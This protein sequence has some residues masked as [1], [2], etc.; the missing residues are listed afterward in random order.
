M[1]AN[2]LD[3]NVGKRNLL[4]TPYALSDMVDNAMIASDG[5]LL[6]GNSY[7]SYMVSPLI[8]VSGAGLY[9]LKVV[10][11]QYLGGIITGTSG[12][13]FYKADGTTSISRQASDMTS[14]GNELYTIQVPEETNYVRFTIYKNSES[15]QARTLACFNQWVFLPNA[16]ADIDASFFVV[17][18]PKTNGAINK[19]YRSDNSYLRLIPGDIIGKNILVFGDSIWGNDRTDGVSDFLAEYSGANIYNCALG[20][21]WI[22]GNRST[23]SGA[24]AWKAFDGV[25]LI[26]AKITNTWTDQDTYVG[27]VTSYA[28]TVLTLLKS[29][30]M[31]KMDIVI[32]SYG[33]NDFNNN[34]SASDIAAAYASAITEILTNY[35]KIRILICSPAWRM[36]N[37][38]DGDEYENTND[39]TLRDVVDAILTMA[40]SNHVEAL[41]MLAHLPWRALT[42]GYYLDNDEVHPNT[43]GNKVY[44]HVVNGKLL[45]MY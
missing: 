16:T 42:K 17:A 26:H 29:V 4:L 7:K 30:D 33:T 9:G 6:T 27:D 31:S 13:A 32:L 15:Y 20:G 28:S 25:N 18:T 40:K 39:E 1:D 5:S 45:T 10:R 41:D 22:Y 12:F 23:Y 8:A 36:F 24:P 14:L 19:L 44:A 11:E 43:E 3:G 35:P 38:T 37:T 21:T 2:N 34:I